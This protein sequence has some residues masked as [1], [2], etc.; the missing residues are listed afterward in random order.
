MIE[1]LV[2]AQQVTTS[3]IVKS[4]KPSRNYQ[5]LDKATE[6]KMSPLSQMY[7]NMREVALAV[8]LL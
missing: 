2:N 3:S 1:D 7:S 4:V 8:N 5:L 6:S